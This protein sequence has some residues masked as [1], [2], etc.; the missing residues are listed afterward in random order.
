MCLIPGSE[1]DEAAHR[2]IDE[3]TDELAHHITPQ[4]LFERGHAHKQLAHLPAAVEDLTRVVRHPQTDAQLRGRAYFFLGVCLRRLGQLEAALHAADHAVELDPSNASVIGHRGYIRSMLGK[5]TDALEDYAEALRLSPRLGVTYAFRGNGWFWQGEYELALA[6]YDQMID[7]NYEDLRFK[8][9]HDRAAARLMVRDLDGA[10]ADVD[11]AEALRPS[12]PWY[13]R[14]ARPLAL[15][16]FTHLIRGDLDRCAT[17]L[18]ESEHLGQTAIG[19]ITSALLDARGGDFG[20]LRVLTT[21]AVR[22]HA[23]GP[24]GG[25]AMVASLI[26]DPIPFLPHLSPLIG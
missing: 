8:V 5:H 23:D 3:L 26:D 17:D 18:H 20:A 25:V 24:M 16:A 2:H 1:A 6:D 15:R 10:L 19:A 9:F 14:D 12:D 11:R 13:P 7:D 4:L 22:E 21:A